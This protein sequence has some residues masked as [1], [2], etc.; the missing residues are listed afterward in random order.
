VEHAYILQGKFSVQYEGAEPVTIEAGDFVSFMTTHAVSIRAC[1]R[2]VLL[3]QVNAVAM[4]NPADK[5]VAS[6]YLQVKFP[7]GM[8]T[9]VVME[10]TRKFF[11]LA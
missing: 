5:F 10:P 9:F 11:N 7:V 3:A 1:N 2:S 8:T 4:T 6:A